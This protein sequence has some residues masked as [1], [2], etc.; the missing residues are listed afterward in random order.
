MRGEG[1]HGASQ[2][3]RGGGSRVA[4]RV[5]ESDSGIRYR[6]SAIGGLEWGPARTGS[7]L[8]AAEKEACVCGR[9]RASDDSTSGAWVT[10][11]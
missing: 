7:A 8:G 9:G 1:M 10:M 2:E 5:N 6:L 11:H 3:A 4:A